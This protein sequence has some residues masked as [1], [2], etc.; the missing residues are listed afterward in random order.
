MSSNDFSSKPW[1]SRVKPSGPTAESIF[2]EYAQIHG[3]SCEKYGFDDSPMD[4]F[5]RLPEFIRFTPDFACVGKIPFLVE[6]KGAGRENHVK[7]KEQMLPALAQWD[8]ITSLFIFVCD[9]SQRLV[10]L[11]PFSELERMLRENTYPTGHYPDKGPPKMYYM[12]PKS[13][14][15]WKRVEDA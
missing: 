14:F 8:H 15:R 4:N 7:I 2:L 6:C 12:V 1:K 3:F 9:V 13:D 10:S 5:Y 11:V